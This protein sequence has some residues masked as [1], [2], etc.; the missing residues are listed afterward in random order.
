MVS[1]KGFLSNLQVKIMGE[2]KDVMIR[3]VTHPEFM[4]VINIIVVD[5]LE[6]YGLL[7]SIYWSEKL[8]RYFSIDWAHLWFPLKGHMNMIK[9]NRERYL[10]HMVTDL[11]TLNKPSSI[12]FPVVGNYSC[13]SYFGN[14]SPLSFDVPLTQ[15]SEMIFQENVLTTIEE[16]LFYQGPTL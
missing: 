8:N 9:I 5:I 7:L 13:D 2:L 11:K 15:K 3:I 6:A 16:T 1:L 14:F 4:Q 10:K 12:D